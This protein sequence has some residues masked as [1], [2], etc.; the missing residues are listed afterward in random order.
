M[1]AALPAH[2]TNVLELTGF[3]NGDEEHPE[4]AIVAIRPST[5]VGTRLNGHPCEMIPLDDV[6]R[7]PLWHTMAQED[8]ERIVW[9]RDDNI[10]S[11][12]SLI[13]ELKAMGRA[14]EAAAL[15]ARPL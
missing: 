4:R 6:M 11:R 3:W 7:H 1:S 8:R 12:A 2:P 5:E 14:E 15:E 13:A 10:R 9:T